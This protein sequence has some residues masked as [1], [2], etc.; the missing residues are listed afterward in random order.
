MT[1]STNEGEVCKAA[2][3]QHE[4]ANKKVWVEFII[5][6]TFLP[7]ITVAAHFLKF[8]GQETNFL[9]WLLKIR[10]EFCR[11]GYFCLIYI[12]IPLFWWRF[13]HTS[14]FLIY[15]TL[16]PSFP[17]IDF[18]FKKME[19]TLSVFTVCLKNWGNGKWMG[20]SIHFTYYEVYHMMWI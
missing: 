19:F 2:Q 4:L 1:V 5:W 8:F 16:N 12:C 11:V 18:S 10:K 6:D 7:N 15:F 17:L 14:F 20:K 9:S 13:I 3:R